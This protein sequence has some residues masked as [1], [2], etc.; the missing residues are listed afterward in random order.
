MNRNL[1][2]GDEKAIAAI[3]A[4]FVRVIKRKSYAEAERFCRKHC[5]SLIGF[6]SPELPRKIS[7]MW[8]LKANYFYECD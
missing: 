4:A 7:R 8:E 5:A 6:D 3:H 1:D 2:M